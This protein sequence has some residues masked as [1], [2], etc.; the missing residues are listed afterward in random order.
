[1]ENPRPDSR[2]DEQEGFP[3]LAVGYTNRRHLDQFIE[4]EQGDLVIHGPIHTGDDVADIA[5]MGAGATEGTP[6]LVIPLI[7]E[8][9]DEIQEEATRALDR[10]QDQPDV[11]FG[12]QVRQGTPR[13]R[14]FGETGGETRGGSAGAYRTGSLEPEDGQRG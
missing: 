2:R 3:H 6:C 4:G 1:M 11:V 8:R 9:I 14:T 5:T 12:R 7:R 10:F 13:P